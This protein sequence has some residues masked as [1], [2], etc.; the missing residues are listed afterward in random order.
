M[1][2][3]IFS[4]EFPLPLWVL[5]AIGFGWFA[6]FWSIILHVVLFMTTPV[7]AFLRAKIL[8]RP[9]AK[10]NFRDGTSKFIAAKKESSGSMT[11]KGLGPFEMIEGSQTKDIASGC[12]IYECFAENA[13]SIPLTYSAIIA[14]LRD[15]G[16]DVINFEQYRILVDLATDEGKRMAYRANVPADKLAAFDEKCDALK[17][18]EL[19]IKPFR[20]YK[21]HELATMFPYNTDPVYVESYSQAQL[22]A[23]ARKHKFSKEILL[24]GA[25]ATFILVIAAFIALKFLGSGNSQPAQTVIQ[26]TPEVL[27]QA[28]QNASHSVTI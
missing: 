1:V 7:I 18:L 9:L 17:K 20:S 3:E 27:R 11:I 13:T 26:I 16:F 19:N 21:M 23:Q 24:Y 25:I 22:N 4:M 10:L 15:K 14:E 5:L 2:L 6:L 12:A 28:A 8:K